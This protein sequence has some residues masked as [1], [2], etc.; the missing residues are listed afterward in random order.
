[1]CNII[2]YVRYCNKEIEIEI[3]LKLAAEQVTQAV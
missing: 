3:E 2:I 1:M